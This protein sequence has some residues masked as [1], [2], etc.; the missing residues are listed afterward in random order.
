MGPDPTSERTGSPL[1]GCLS[2]KTTLPTWDTSLTTGGLLL[3]SDGPD[4]YSSS[5]T[6]S[7]CSTS[8]DTSM[9]SSLEP[10]EK[11]FQS[12]HHSFSQSQLLE[13]MLKEKKKR[14]EEDYD[15]KQV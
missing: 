2:W 14:N 4:G 7:S 3:S 11:N 8:K 13:E 12:S 15:L 6:S 5:S 1:P 9:F 10:S